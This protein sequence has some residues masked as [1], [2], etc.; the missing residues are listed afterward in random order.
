[1]IVPLL[2]LRKSK[3][4][5]LKFLSLPRD[6]INHYLLV[7]Q[8]SSTCKLPKMQLP[9]LIQWWSP[10]ELQRFWF[11]NVAK[12]VITFTLKINCRKSEVGKKNTNDDFAFLF[13]TPKWWRSLLRDDYFSAITY[14]WWKKMEPLPA[15]YCRKWSLIR[16][17]PAITSQVMVFGDD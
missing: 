17:L 7:N 3:E 8:R 12:K 14:K 2:K 10:N 11:Q 4:K 13:I 1:M 9:R 6:D 15:H 5:L 16:S